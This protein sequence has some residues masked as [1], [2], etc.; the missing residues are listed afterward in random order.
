MSD[1]VDEL[2]AT[3]RVN[4]KGNAGIDV[5]VNGIVKLA[6]LAYGEDYIIKGFE[7]FAEDYKSVF[8]GDV[9]DT[10]CYGLLES[11]CISHKIQQVN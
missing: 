9:L 3:I 4:F 2:P 11:V 10:Y 7:A 6:L 8:C 5:P 1:K